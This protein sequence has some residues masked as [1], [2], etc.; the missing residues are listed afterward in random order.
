M[1]RKNK[2][3]R[4]KM[5]NELTKTKNNIRENEM[6]T[7]Q[8]NN[9]KQEYYYLHYVDMNFNGK[10]IREDC[11]TYIQL[12]RRIRYLSFFNESVIKNL[13]VKTLTEKECN[14]ILFVEDEKK[15]TR[16]EFYREFWGKNQNREL[17]YNFPID[18][19]YKMLEID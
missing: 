1:I 8:N 12:M 13:T 18:E 6:T 5:N 7:N 3:E 10:L 9:Q 17:Q 15:V 19:N 16:L 11:L 14:E 4:N 2:K